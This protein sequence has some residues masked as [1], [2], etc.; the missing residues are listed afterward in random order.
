MK[1]QGL[2]VSCSERLSGDTLKKGSG[3][4]YTAKFPKPYESRDNL[5]DMRKTVNLEEIRRYSAEIARWFLL[6]R[7]SC[8]VDTRKLYR[9]ADYAVGVM[10]VR[11]A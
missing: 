1:R 5:M 6:E 10:G 4:G 9:W 8:P 7:S 3:R 11:L 2:R